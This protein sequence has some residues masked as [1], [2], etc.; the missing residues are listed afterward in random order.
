MGDL[1][2]NAITWTTA[3]PIEA[4][5]SDKRGPR[6]FS[7]VLYNGGP[8]MVARYPL[9]I[10]VD[11]QGLYGLDRPRPLSRDHD[12]NRL[13]GHID[14]VANNGQSVTISGYVSVPS[15]DA[16]EVLAAHDG[17]FPWQLSIEALP[18]KPI[19]E[20]PAGQRVTVNRRTF[21]GP[22]LVARKAKF[23]G[24]SV[25]PH[26]ADD[27]TNLSIAANRKR[28]DSMSTE[29]IDQA[30]QA[31]RQRVAG[32]EATFAGLKFQSEGVQHRA[33]QLRAK[34]LAGEISAEAFEA[35]IG[36]CK[37]DDAEL[38]R[39]RADYP[40]GPAI[41]A[42]T[43]DIVASVIEAA[44]ARTAGLHNWEK[45]YKPELLEASDRLGN[46]GLQETLLIA[47]QA[48]GYAGGRHRIDSSNLRDVLSYACP[49]RGAFSTV[50]TPGVL[51]NVG[52]KFLLEGFNAV[53]QVWRQIAR[54]KPVVDFKQ[55]TSYRLNADAIY[56]ELA[57]TGE[58][59]HGS[60]TEESFTNQVRTYAR[61]FAISRTDI[62]ND[63]LGAFDDIR[64]RLGRGAA[65]KLNDTFWR[66][67]LDNSTFFTAARGNYQ[68]GAN[69][70]L[71]DAGTAL[72]DAEI[73]FAALT[74]AN[75]SPLGVEPAILLVPADLSAIAR[76][77]Y[78][79]AEIR[80][81]TSS[82]RYPTGNIF[83]N[84]YRPLTSAYLNKST[85]TGYSSTAW[86]L[87]ADPTNLATMEVCFLNG[88]ES[89]T[90]ESA[91]ADFNTLG[92]QFRGYHDF[93]VALA[94]YR[95]G[96][97]SKGSA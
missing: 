93:G 12:D 38:T 7:G 95:A 94:E 48:N 10:I 51:S 65:L 54:V 80:D 40:K 81:T 32:I 28:G 30:I 61:M 3:F 43:R 22:V 97:K 29:T 6:R 69:T 16:A 33:A 24:A 50:N 71:T 91:D 75:G 73:L 52:N 42:G 60:L 46:I 41:H 62:I 85:Y 55:A 63:D 5:A 8:L 27:A 36:E 57:P 4:A 88:Q 82:T 77:L 21:K 53:E 89:P 86:Y 31:E 20:I 14:A 74:D 13:V 34:A 2:L 68:E 39:I 19:E 49:I 26:G 11:L 96:I 66:A 90:V 92:I 76:R 64:N 59:H 9:P 37:R 44:F 47:A 70:E 67:F 78:V 25:V 58:I 35:G 56:D 23:T 17:G 79:S 84:K 83:Q 45:A 15:S 87:L 1:N 18:E 72:T